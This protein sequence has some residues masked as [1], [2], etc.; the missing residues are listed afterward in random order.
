MPAESAPKSRSRRRTGSGVTCLTCASF[1]ADLAARVDEGR[2]TARTRSDEAAV[3]GKAPHK[4]HGKYLLS[5][6]MRICATVSGHFKAFQE[7]V[8]SAHHLR[9]RDAAPQ[10]GRLHEHAHRPRFLRLAFRR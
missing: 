1:D 5:G 4:A 3:T 6:R 2:A 8:E 10:A 7:A 9:L